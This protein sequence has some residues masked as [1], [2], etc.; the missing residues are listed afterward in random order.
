MLD[1]RKKDIRDALLQDE[2]PQ[3]EG[4]SLTGSQYMDD[5]IPAT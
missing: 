4:G 3:L 1:N 5:G 2:P